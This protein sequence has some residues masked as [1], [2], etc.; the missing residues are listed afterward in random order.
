[1]LITINNSDS[2]YFSSYRLWVAKEIILDYPMN[3]TEKALDKYLW[4]SS[5]ILLKDACLKI[6]D[7]IKV[8]NSTDI[9][10]NIQNKELEKLYRIITYGTG[11]IK[12]SKILLNALR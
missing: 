9:T 7:N 6:I 3:E 12:G 10:L 4:T 2:Q 8:T 5:K 1:M 11:K